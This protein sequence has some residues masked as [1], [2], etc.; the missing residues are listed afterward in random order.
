VSNAAGELVR[1][2]GGVSAGEKLTL[3]FADGRVDARADG[4]D[5]RGGAAAEGEIAAAA[6]ASRKRPRQ[7]PDDGGQQS[8][9]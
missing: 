4:A 1:S 2:A 6:P 8:L 3:E 9:F 7:P 5:Q